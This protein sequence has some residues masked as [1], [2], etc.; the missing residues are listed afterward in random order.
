MLTLSTAA[1]I[2]FASAG[3]WPHLDAREQ[4]TDD[5]LPRDELKE[6]PQAGWC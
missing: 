4:E 1:P 2:S 5:K 3:A 6:M